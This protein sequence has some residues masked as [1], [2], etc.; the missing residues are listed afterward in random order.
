MANQ[1]DFTLKI[2]EHM[3]TLNQ[4]NAEAQLYKG[5]VYEIWDDLYMA[6][7]AYEKFIQVG[8]NKKLGYQCLA[9]LLWLER[10]AIADEE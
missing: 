6:E 3:E 9:H 4:N 5:W 2:I 7:E 10:E 1:H 8:G